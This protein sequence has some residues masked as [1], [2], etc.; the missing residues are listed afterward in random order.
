M[1]TQPG[2]PPIPL[3]VAR[4]FFLRIDE[5]GLKSSADG[6]SFD[7]KPIKPGQFQVGVGATKAGPEARISVVTPTPADVGR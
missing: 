4:H 1:K 3:R 5:G 2:A 6:K 7:A